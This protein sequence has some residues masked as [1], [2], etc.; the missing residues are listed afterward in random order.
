MVQGQEG[1]LGRCPVRSAW[2]FM[3]DRKAHRGWGGMGPQMTWDDHG[4][5][6]RAR[7]AS[8]QRFPRPQPWICTAPHTRPVTTNSGGSWPGLQPLLTAHSLPGPMLGSRVQGSLCEE[9]RP[10]AEPGW[11][12]QGG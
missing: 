12:V 2:D 7:Q 11:A 4:W 1:A 10:G 8:A 3:A 9:E 5:L 6:H